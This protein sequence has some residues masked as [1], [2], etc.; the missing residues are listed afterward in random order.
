MD[1]IAKLQCET[2]LKVA[3]LMQRSE[4]TQQNTKKNQEIVTEFNFPL[5]TIDEIATCDEKLRANE[6]AKRD[7][8]SKSL[9]PIINIR[10]FQFTF[11]IFSR[12]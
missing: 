12:K 2:N 5:Q 6:Q 10:S 1:W 3:D 7:F 9:F 11:Q 8:V 4:E